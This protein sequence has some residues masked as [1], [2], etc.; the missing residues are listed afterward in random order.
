MVTVIFFQWEYI[1]SV[2][3][4]QGF[5][6]HTD[7][8]RMNSEKATLSHT[9]TN[10]RSFLPLLMVSTNAL[11]EAGDIRGQIMPVVTVQVHHC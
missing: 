6:L 10:T 4:P 9:A 1:I 5:L 11:E 3:R 8:Q 2:T 7:T